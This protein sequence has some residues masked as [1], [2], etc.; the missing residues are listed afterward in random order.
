MRIFM[1]APISWSLCACAPAVNEY[2]I[3]GLAKVHFGRSPGG[4]SRPAALCIGIDAYEVDT[5]VA[6]YSSFA[7]IVAET[8][9]LEGWKSVNISPAADIHASAVAE[10]L[11]YLVPRDY[12]VQITP[13]R[14]E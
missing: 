7:E 14:C 13:R 6:T 5:G 1:L 8:N 3:T 12:D 10:V 4:F 2:Q 11:D 9:A